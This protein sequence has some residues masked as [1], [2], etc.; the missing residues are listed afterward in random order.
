VEL[1]KPSVILAA[2]DL[3]TALLQQQLLESRKQLRASRAACEVCIGKAVLNYAHV[4]LWRREC[5]VPSQ[6]AS[7]IAGG[8]G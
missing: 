7:D 6:H 8:P 4:V 1:L 2:P 3:M 5:H